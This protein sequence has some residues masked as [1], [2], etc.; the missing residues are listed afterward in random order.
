MEKSTKIIVTVVIVIAF[1]FLMA[2]VGFL[3]ES[4]GHSTPGI[5]GIAVGCVFIAALRAL[6]KK[7][8]DNDDNHPAK[9]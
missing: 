7:P 8:K 6:W 4:A 5:L 3:R 9:N 2:L 1:I